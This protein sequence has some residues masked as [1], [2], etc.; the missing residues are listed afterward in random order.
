[1]LREWLPKCLGWALLNPKPR[2]HEHNIT[3][4]K[5]KSWTALG[6]GH[7]LPMPVRQVIP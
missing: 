3:E 7:Y 4:W 6:E 2:F 1:M 5:P